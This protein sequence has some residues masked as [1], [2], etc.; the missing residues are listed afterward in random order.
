MRSDLLSG[1]LQG[2]GGAS[3]SI[4]AGGSLR[5]ASRVVVSNV[6]AMTSWWKKESAI[7]EIVNIVDTL[8]Q[9]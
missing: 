2:P 5:Q 8:S 4:W 7:W 3:D 1:A 9:R 6:I